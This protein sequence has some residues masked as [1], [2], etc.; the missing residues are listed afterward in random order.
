MTVAVAGALVVV[1]RE[2]EEPVAAG[3]SQCQWSPCGSHPTEAVGLGGRDSV[4][5]SSSAEV[6]GATVAESLVTA[7]SDVAVAGPSQCLHKKNQVRT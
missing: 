6:V 7:L 5:S 1:I 3:P 4:P 2:D